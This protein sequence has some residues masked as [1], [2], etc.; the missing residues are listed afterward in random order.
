MRLSL[1]ILHKLDV[2]QVV[3]VLVEE[4]PLVVHEILVR[5]LLGSPD[6]D[7]PKV[8]VVEFLD[9][10]DAVEELLSFERGGQVAHSNNSFKE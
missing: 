7:F 9:E 3:L 2:V 8:L 1:Q 5:D 10:G 6:F 4:L